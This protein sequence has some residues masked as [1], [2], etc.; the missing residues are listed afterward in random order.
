MSVRQIH[1]EDLI[2]QVLDTF[3]LSSE[4]DEHVAS[5]FLLPPSGVPDLLKVRVAL[6]PTNTQK[7]WLGKWYANG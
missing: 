5:N 7:C 1:M 6:S 3:Y 4:F 2:Q